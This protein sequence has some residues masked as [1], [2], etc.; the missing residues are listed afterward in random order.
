MIL[1]FDGHPFQYEMEAVCKLF[2][3]TQLFQHEFVLVDPERDDL[4]I[5]QVTA[6]DQGSRL[7]ASA[8]HDG[9]FFE[10]VELVDV[11]VQSDE[12]ECER[13]LGILLFSVLSRLTGLTPVW[14]IMT[15][16]RPVK[17]YHYLLE[18]GATVAQ[19][20]RVFTKD[21]LVQPEKLALCKQISAIQLPIIEASAPN[22]YS[23]YVSI[24]FCP[25][26]CSYC[27]FVSSSV[28][29]PKAQALVADYL[30]KLC[31][32]LAVIGTYAKQAG[33]KLETVY[34]GGGTPTTLTAAQL[35]RLFD[36]MYQ[37]FPMETATEFTVEAGRA[38]TITQ[39]KLLAI[40]RAKATRISINPQT[41]S[42]QTLQTI[43][44][45]HSAK[46]VLDCYAMA[47]ELGFE[48]I[49]MDLIAGLPGETLEQFQQSVDTVLSLDP[50]NV[51]VHTLTIK[52]SSDLFSKVVADCP[53]DQMVAYAYQQMSGQ[54]YLP[55]Y[56]YRQK[57]T[58]HNLENIG[59]A[60][61]GFEGLYNIYIME[62]IHTIL[63]AGAGAVSK[64]IREKC[65]KVQRIFNY[66]YPFEYNKGFDEMVVRKKEIE[67]FYCHRN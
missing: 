67:D 53:V 13:L 23:L 3:A 10:A 26:R 34:V 40:K 57:N 28:A 47:K 4:I 43:G 37:H 39:E 54:G 5:T 1:V 7:Y 38:D 52:R 24:P 31:T 29:T 32:E 6:T 60:K 62:E 42:D 50:T 49:N 18:K 56:M 66:K 27:S 15:G 35:T 51:T 14:G 65:Q 46:Q 41:F 55:Y 30:E 2:F 12:K 63:A 11:T 58:L 61:A 59:Y 8:R 21:F 25:T 20:D 16:I 19:A 17:Q 33:L 44:R 64:L 22:S 36:C 9:K 48:D 45:N